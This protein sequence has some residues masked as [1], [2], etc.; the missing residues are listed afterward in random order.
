MKLRLTFRGPNIVSNTTKTEPMG[1]GHAIAFETVMADGYV[2]GDR[3]LYWLQRIFD[4]ERTFNEVTKG[5]VH[6]EVIE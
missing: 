2:P 3:S 6:I 4:M 1:I 5:R